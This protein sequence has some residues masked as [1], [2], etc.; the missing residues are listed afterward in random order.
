MKYSPNKLLITPKV[1]DDKYANEIVDRAKILN[2]SLVVEDVNSNN[3]LP[4]QLFEQKKIL[5]YLK[6]TIVL[7]ERAGS[8]ISTFA[9]PGDIVEEMCVIMTMGWHCSMNCEYC[10]LQASAR[11]NSQHI[12]YTNLDKIGNEMLIE[13]FIHRIILTILTANSFINKKPLM[14]IPGGFHEIGNKIRLQLQ[15]R[16][17]NRVESHEEAIEFV[18]ANLR[19]YLNMMNPQSSYFLLFPRLKTVDKV[20]KQWQKNHDDALKKSGN[21]LHKLVQDIRKNKYIVGAQYISDELDKIKLSNPS[22]EG[23]INYFKKQ[24]DISPSNYSDDKINEVIDQVDDFYQENMAYSPIL[25]IS[26]YTDAVGIQHISKNLGVF[27]EMFQKHDDIEMVL[28]TKSANVDDILK[29]DGMDRSIITM[30]FNT[31]YFIQTFEHGTSTLDER[32]DAAIKIQKSNGFRLNVS[33][34]PMFFYNDYMDDYKKLVDRL[35]TELDVEN[36]DTVILGTAR[37]GRL[38]KS[39]VPDIHPNTDVFQ[40]NKPLHPIKGDDSKWRYEDDLREEMYKEIIDAFKKY[41]NFYFF[42]GAETPEMWLNVGLDPEA[43]M[44]KFMYQYS[45]NIKPAN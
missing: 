34:E 27:M 9:S 45:N 28:P 26:E 20:A 21:E 43:H 22:I 42:L 32:I 15:T 4:P 38:L 23:Q 24:L 41:G 36:I 5:E 40:K 17:T 31:D 10:Y 2:P 18:K 7:K 29:Y 6:E 14:K 8:F 16:K 44:K 35:M 13:P 12:L 1:K 11:N 25:N 39:I 19:N 3:P 37:F 30:N 33:I